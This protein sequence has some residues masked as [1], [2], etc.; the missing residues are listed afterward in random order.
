MIINNDFA[1]DC[2]KC[3]SPIFRCHVMVGGGYP[4]AAHSSRTGAP[5]RTAASRGSVTHTG[6]TDNIVINDRMKK[7]AHARTIWRM[8]E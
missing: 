5:S 3:I 2:S 6:A 7:R 4:L 1:T 8:A